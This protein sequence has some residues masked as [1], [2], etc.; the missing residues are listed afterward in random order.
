MTRPTT[1][2]FTPDWISPPGETIVDLLEER[3]WSQSELADRLGVTPKHVSCV[4][5]GQASISESLAIKLERVL[6]SSADFWMRREHQ[7]RIAQQR[8][9]TTKN[10]ASWTDWLNELPVKELM[11]NGHIQKVRLTEKNKPAIVEELLNFFRIASPDEWRSRYIDIEAR[12]R[13][14]THK[15]SLPCISA[16]LRLGEIEAEKMRVGNF[17]RRLFEQNLSIARTLTSKPA[18]SF[19]SQLKRLCSEAG[20]RLVFVPALKGARVSGVARWLGRNSPLI[21]LSLYGKSNDLFWFTFFHECAHILLHERK[22]LFID[23]FDDT[24]DATSCEQEADEW[25]KNLLIAPQYRSILPSL[26]SKS[27][28]QEFA[29]RIGIHPG[30]VVGRLQHDGHIPFSWMNGLKERT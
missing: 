5:S 4:I 21:Q 14:V 27:E 30:I 23:D 12:Y 9:E 2:A 10:L 7:F 26:Q 29:N 18:E 1:K 17:D 25:A 16:W 22:S 19:Q 24:N 6:G 8:I 3:S 15:S 20:V 11:H 13:R 28:V